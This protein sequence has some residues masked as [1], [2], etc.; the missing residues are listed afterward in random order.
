MVLI[1]NFE[2]DSFEESIDYASAQ[3][4]IGDAGL[5]AELV[6][7]IFFE[8]R[9]VDCGTDENLLYGFKV[10]PVD[11]IDPVELIPGIF[12]KHLFHLPVLLV[13]LVRVA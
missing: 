6:K 8:V 2:I 1:I 13:V 5:V 7:R 10:L 12:T 9:C 11:L 3:S 4:P